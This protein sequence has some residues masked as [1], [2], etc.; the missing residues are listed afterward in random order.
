MNTM[1]ATNAQRDELGSSVPPQAWPNG[2]DAPLANERRSTACCS[3]A[4]LRAADLMSTP[5]SPIPDPRSH[6]GQHDPGAAGGTMRAAI[7]AGPAANP[8]EQRPPGHGCDGRHDADYRRYVSP[9]DTLST[10]A[11]RMRHTRFAD[12]AVLDARGAV[13]GVITAAT[14]VQVLIQ[15]ESEHHR[16]DREDR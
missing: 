12:L 9:G 14:V 8:T 5:R 6:A 13:V 4:E 16:P 2:I 7:I 1:T 15:S 10:I 11:Q 3:L